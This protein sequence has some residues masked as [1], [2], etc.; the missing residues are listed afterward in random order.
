MLLDCAQHREVRIRLQGCAKARPTGSTHRARM[1]NP[2][3]A[4]G[5]IAAVFE[6]IGMLALPWPER[7]IVSSRVAWDRRKFRSTRTT[8]AGTY[9]RF[10]PRR[11]RT[12]LICDSAESRLITGKAVASAHAT[13]PVLLWGFGRTAH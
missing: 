6:T 2:E 7:V 12:S 5:S 3:H 11:G 10:V 13:P 9:C 8:S 4:P 1:R